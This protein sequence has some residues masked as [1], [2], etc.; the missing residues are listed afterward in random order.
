[1][2]CGVE[3]AGVAA[4]LDSNLVRQQ[5]PRHHHGLGLAAAASRLSLLL[6]GS[7][8]LG[9]DDVVTLLV[10]VGSNTRAAKE[11]PGLIDLGVEASLTQSRPGRVQPRLDP[12]LGSLKWRTRTLQFCCSFSQAA[13]TEPPRFG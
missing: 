3:I 4:V 2:D 13:C 11:A 10:V 1:M 5:L 6:L 9:C 7:L 12:L 8:L